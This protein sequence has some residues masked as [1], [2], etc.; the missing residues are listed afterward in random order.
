MRFPADRIGSHQGAVDEH[1]DIVVAREGE[2]FASVV[3]EGC[4][5]LSREG[6]VVRE[7]FIVE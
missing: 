4:R 5:Y 7:A 1:E 2:G 6:V 3:A